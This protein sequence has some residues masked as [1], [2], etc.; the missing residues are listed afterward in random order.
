MSLLARREEIDDETIGYI[1]ASISAQ[2][3]RDEAERKAERQR[4]ETE[5]AAKRKR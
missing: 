2:R 4:L 1:E 3:Q 5:E